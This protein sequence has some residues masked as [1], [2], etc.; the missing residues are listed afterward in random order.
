VT[1]GGLLGIVLTLNEAEH[2]QDC[3]ASLRRLTD[4]VI[5]LDSG[6][7]DGTRAI[8][9]AAGAEW[10]ARPFDGYASQRNAALLLA[11]GA[12]WVLF[13]DA[14]E[15]LTEAGAA[16]IRA[17]L[18]SASPETAAFWLPRRNV[19]FGRALRGGGWWPDAQARLLRPG[20]AHYDPNRQ[21][22]EV[23]VIDGESR[24]L[25]QPMI[26]FN[27]AS[28]REFVTK[29]RVYTSQRVA[30]A[31]GET[32]PRLRALVGAPAREFWRR[33]VRLKGYRDG[34][35]GLFLAGVL[36][37]EEARAVWLLRRKARR[38]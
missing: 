18:E 7:T 26:H 22:H 19:F 17:A 2:L 13:L 38:S 16:E 37:C 32:V 1:A 3:L 15:R 34:L 29:Q 28:R 36:A 12:E 4:D 11:H 6:S 21:V 25:R 8:A 23:L 27:Y 24:R 14:D 35:T 9:L 5:V 33:F 30:M 31:D 10:H 20:R